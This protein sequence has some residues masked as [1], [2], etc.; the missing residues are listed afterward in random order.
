MEGQAEF[1]RFSQL[2]KLNE[3]IV[4]IKNE[5]INTNMMNIYWNFMIIKMK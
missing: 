1:E 3:H 5:A 2:G 4:L